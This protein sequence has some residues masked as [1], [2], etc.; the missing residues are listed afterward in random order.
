[1]LASHRLP[2]FVALVALFV[3]LAFLVTACGQTPSAPAATAA[4]SKAAA[5]ATT[6]A[7]AAAAPTNAPE[8]TKPAAAPTTAAAA[9]AKKIDYPTKPVTV[10][11]PWP[12]GGGVDVGARMMSGL[13][14]KELSQPFQVLNKA[15]ASGQVGNTEAANSKPDGY[16]FVI[17]GSPTFEATYLDP[18]R[19]STYKGTSF[20][21][22]ANT[23]LDPN[24]FCVLA[25]SKYTSLEDVIKALKDKPES[26]VVGTSGLM[27]DDHLAILALEQKAGV[28]FAI[29]HFA[30]G[31]PNLTALQGGH[32]DVMVGNIGDA[33]AG[34]QA[35]TFRVLAVASV[36]KSSFL[37]EAPTFKDQGIDIVSAVARGWLAPAGTPPEIIKIVSDAMKKVNEMPEYQDK[38]K[39]AGFPVAFMATEEYAKY[40]QA[41]EKRVAELLKA[42]Q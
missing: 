24:T 18:S 5:P 12:A 11:V 40:L 3:T 29:T 2:S 23:V 7:P 42:A 36:E 10:I 21:A 17:P 31:A 39:A 34:Y 20:T 13:L 22:V 14:E 38:M 33:I 41:E 27:T 26:V 9:P 32:I 35:K 15:G 1:M 8:A 6:T 37:P 25:T 16:T 28:K 30:G 19:G 4:P